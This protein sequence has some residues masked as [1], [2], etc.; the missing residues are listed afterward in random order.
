MATI[1]NFRPAVPERDADA[2]VAG[3]TPSAEVI[4]FP[5]VRY[6]HWDDAR[7]DGRTRLQRSAKSK[8]ERGNAQR[9][10]LEIAE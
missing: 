9:D 8:G 10:V 2:H 7:E 3:D 5:G 1:L 6:E 4:V